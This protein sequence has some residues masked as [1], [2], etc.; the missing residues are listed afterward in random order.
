MHTLQSIK[1]DIRIEYLVLHGRK[2]STAISAGPTNKFKKIFDINESGHHFLNQTRAYNNALALASLGCNKI[3]APGYS[4]TFKIQRKLYHRIG[5]LLPSSPEVSPKFAQLYFHDSSHELQNKFH[6]AQLRPETL[7]ILQEELH[8][9]N[10]Y[11][12]SFKAAIELD[13]R[14]NLKVILHA[15]KALKPQEANR[16]IYNLPSTSEVAVIIPSTHIGNL[17]VIV[18]C[19]D[20]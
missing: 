14:E 3:V 10:S 7:Q 16:R 5:L 2:K 6:H 4:P 9:C 19:R 11:I 8:S 17:D 12:R 18:H 20:G 1:M 15:H 13:A